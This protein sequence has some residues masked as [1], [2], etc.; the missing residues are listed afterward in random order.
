MTQSSADTVR[1]VYSAFAA[2]DIPGVIALMS[3]DIIWNEAENF[4]YADRSPYRGP[5]EI[6][7]GVFARLGEEWDGFAAVAEELLDCGDTVV[8]LGRYRGTY[9]ASGKAVD[10][11]MVHVWR[12]ADGRVTAFQQYAD[13]LQFA[14]AT[15]AA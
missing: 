9:K 5:D 2:G 1:A 15:G 6:V 7:S 13:T 3:P 8:A 10:A 11:Q 14:R 12:V 4:P